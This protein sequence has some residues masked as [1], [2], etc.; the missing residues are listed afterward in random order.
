MGVLHRVGGVRLDGQKIARRIVCI[1]FILVLVCASCGAEVHPSSS[2]FPKSHLILQFNSEQATLAALDLLLLEPY[3]QTT[4]IDLFSSDLAFI[5]I[6]THSALPQQVKDPYFLLPGIQQVVEDGIRWLETDNTE[7]FEEISVNDPL[8]PQQ[9]GLRMMQVPQTWEFTGTVFDT[10]SN[11]TVAIVDTGVDFTHPDLAGTYHPASYDWVSGTPQITDANGHGTHLAGIIA[12]RTDN[13][14][15]ISGIAPVRILSE[16]VHEEGVGI[17]TSRSAMGIYHAA[18]A[19][20]QI[21]VLGYG[22]K[23]F[24]DIEARAISYAKEQGSLIIASAGND[25]SNASHYPSDLSDVISVGAISESGSPSIFSNY[26]IFLDFVGPGQNIYGTEPGNR[27]SRKA[28]TSQAA[29][30]VAG[31]AALLWSLD[32]NQTA[33]DLHSLLI[34]SA[35][36]LGKE[37]K[38][39]YFGW[40]YPNSLRAAQLLHDQSI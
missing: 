9:W 24:S 7:N 34:A 2:S 16:T 29:A 6:T 5:S 11:I 25:Q 19:G 23:I 36:D 31:V 22:G 10:C 30:G 8:F 33:Q 27:Y 38:D 1:C 18:Q 40:G 20:A 13:H 21:I 37:G 26:G 12:A 35:E 39:I 17:L 3:N 14:M 32:M 15:G 4:T 28:G